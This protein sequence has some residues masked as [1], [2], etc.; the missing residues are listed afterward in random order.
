MYSYTN[1][2]ARS[3][4]ASLS[5]VGSRDGYS[6][7]S[8]SLY[9]VVALHNPPLYAITWYSVKQYEITVKLLHI[10]STCI[11]YTV[12]GIPY[13]G[14]TYFQCFCAQLMVLVL[15]GASKMC[16]GYQ[17]LMNS[18]R[19]ITHFTIIF[20]TSVPT[21]NHQSDHSIVFSNP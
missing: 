4:P 8:T 9:S 11:W 17:Y 20:L 21:S 6:V 1:S 12:F 16:R 7:S 14:Y 18:Y 19:F 10:S 3:T 5:S 2:T 15:P 13:L